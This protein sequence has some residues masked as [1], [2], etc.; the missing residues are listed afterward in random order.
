MKQLMEKMI[1]KNKRMY[2]AFVDLEEA[3]V[4]VSREKLW[5]VLEGYNI[6]GMLLTGTQALYEVKQACVRVE[7]RVV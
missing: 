7:S 3:Y 6:C 2:V 4:T 1:E 5:R